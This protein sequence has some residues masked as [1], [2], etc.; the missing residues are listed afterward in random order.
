M[1][2]QMRGKLSIFPAG[3]PA[4]ELHIEPNE[5]HY[6]KMEINGTYGSDLDDWLDASVLLSKK[7]INCSYSLE[8]ITIPL[9]D[10]QKAYEAAST[11]GAYRVAVDLQGV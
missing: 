8:G 10:I 2:K 3:Y 7:L 6:R 5:I 4:P 9:R 11:P 1:L